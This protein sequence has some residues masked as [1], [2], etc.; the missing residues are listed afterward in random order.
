[1]RTSKILTYLLYLFV[2]FGFLAAGSWATS[3]LKI[4][5]GRTFRP[6]P[7]FIGS[8]FIF[9]FIGILMGLEDFVIQYNR[10]GKWSVNITKLI[11]LGIPSAVFAFYLVLAFTFVIPIP[12]FIYNGYLFSEVSAL[13]FGYTIVTS[14]NKKQSIFTPESKKSAH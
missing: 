8:S 12:S 14:F 7:W 3:M 11:I 4:W 9:I 5:A 13:I 6:V 10:Q 2:L 1:M